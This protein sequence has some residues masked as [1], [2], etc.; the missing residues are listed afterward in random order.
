[1]KRIARAA[2]AL[3]VLACARASTPPPTVVAASAAPVSEGATCLAMSRIAKAVDAITA[4][5]VSVVDMAA[6]EAPPPFQSCARNVNEHPTKYDGHFYVCRARA[7]D[8]TAL[9]ATFRRC[10]AKELAVANRSERDM[11]FTDDS[12]TGISFDL[13][14]TPP[15]FRYRGCSLR[16]DDTG[17]QFRCGTHNGD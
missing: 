1:M 17:A 14:M 10:F 11:N 13:V 3:V 5:S 6:A 16:R 15:P 2:P 12:D 9:A 8:M 7:A 4:S